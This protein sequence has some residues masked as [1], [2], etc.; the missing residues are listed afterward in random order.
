MLKSYGHGLRVD[1]AWFQATACGYCQYGLLV[2]AIDV[3]IELSTECQDGRMRADQ[4]SRYFYLLIFLLYF[5]F[6]SVYPFE[7]NFASFIKLWSWSAKIFLI[8]F[9]VLVEQIHQ[10]T[11]G[12][13]PS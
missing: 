4:L 10:A 13:M 6:S 11:T 12:K 8:F 3:D 9:T 7:C 1:L 5:S 2:Y